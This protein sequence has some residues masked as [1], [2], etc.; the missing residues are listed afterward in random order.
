[1]AEAVI[2]VAFGN[3]NRPAR[4]TRRAVFVEMTALSW[5][6]ADATCMA[7][8][9]TWVGNDLPDHELSCSRPSEPPPWQPALLF[10]NES[11]RRFVDV[12]EK[13]GSY[14]RRRHAARG[15]AVADLD[16]DGGL[17]LVLSGLEEPTTLLRHRHPPAQWVTITLQSSSGDPTGLGAEISLEAFERRAMIAMRAGTSFASHV[18]PQATFALEADRKSVNVTVRWLSGRQ[19]VF[20]ELPVSQSHRLRERSGLDIPVR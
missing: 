20:H 4:S 6:L 19:E 15:S 8:P 1:L 17:D 12:S 9:P 18:D 11:G 13:A 10:R 2:V 14:F 7:S 3:T 5:K 16:G